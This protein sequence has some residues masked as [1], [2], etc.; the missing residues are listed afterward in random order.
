MERGRAGPYP[1]FP[2]LLLLPTPSDPRGDGERGRE[3]E[4]EGERKWRERG[5]DAWALRLVEA[6]SRLP[7]AARSTCPAPAPK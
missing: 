4:R 3:R 6:V 1:P 7:R 5:R 2:S